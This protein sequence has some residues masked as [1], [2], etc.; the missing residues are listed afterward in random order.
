MGRSLRELL[1]KK[2]PAAEHY[3]REACFPCPY[4]V[5]VC[6]RQG[7]IYRITCNKCKDEGKK[8]AVYIR[9]TARIIFDNGLEHFRAIE[10]Q[11][12]ESPM[13]DHRLEEHAGA[14]MSF[15]MEAIGF[16]S[17]ALW[18]QATEASKIRVHGD[19][20]VINRK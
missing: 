5:G 2:D 12:E 3:S 9:E 8:D 7:V 18:R 16:Q 20:N 14:P 6:M 15:R 13:V 17:S 10:S 4:K 1:V 19:R 11:N